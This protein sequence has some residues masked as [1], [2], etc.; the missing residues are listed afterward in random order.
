MKTGLILSGVSTL[1]LL[2]LCACGTV[3][4]RTSG[5]GGPYHGLGYDMEKASRGDAWLDWSGHGSAGNVPI[6]WPS[7][8]LWVLDVPFSFTADTLLLPVDL[9]RPKAAQAEPESEAGQPDG[10]AK[11]KP[12]SSL[13]R[14]ED[15]RPPPRRLR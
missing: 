7:G 2:L 9:L 11:G 5:T 4:T 6:L 1:A 8:L 10:A 14:G 12:P 3:K 13:P 15:S